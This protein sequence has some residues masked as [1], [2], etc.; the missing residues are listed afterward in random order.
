MSFADESIRTAAFAR[1]RLLESFYGDS[2]PWSEIEKGFNVNGNK[3]FLASKAEG[4]FKPKELTEG[5]LS[6]KTT[7]PKKGRHNVYDD[8]E[9]ED[10]YFHYSLKASG[11]LRSNH[12]LEQ[13][14]KKQLPLIYFIGIT[15]GF[16]KAVFPCFI[17]DINTIANSALVAP[18]RH[19]ENYS[20]S[21]ANSE[22]EIAATSV[23]RKYA[24]REVKARL[25]QEAFRDMV[26]SAYQNKCAI[27]GLP[28]PALLE[29]AHIIPDSHQLGHAEVKN[30]ICLSRLHHKAFDAMLIGI[31]PDHTIVVSEKLKSMNDG[32]VLEYGLKQIDGMKIAI[33]KKEDLKPS[34]QYLEVRWQHFLEAN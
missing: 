29:A 5:A 27:S 6:I 15:P 2:I 33:P 26:L 17:N 3:I 4:I 34:S 19:I 14:W 25:H 7:V 30:G 23:E 24:V 13:S 11:N 9:A 28:V 32:P 10:G 8:K 31:R 16:Y 18:G 1:V 12:Y 20:H 22:V 21:A